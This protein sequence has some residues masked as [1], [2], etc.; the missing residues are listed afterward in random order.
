MKDG[1]NYDDTNVFTL[2]IDNILGLAGGR[3]TAA[4]T[5]SVTTASTSAAS[6]TT[7]A[8]PSSTSEFL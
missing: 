5:P 8:T 1:C 3:P 6:S 4:T 2:D 7:L